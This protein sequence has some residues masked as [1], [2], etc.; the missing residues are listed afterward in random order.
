[1]GEVSDFAEPLNEI[2]VRLEAEQSE[3][4]RDDQEII[5]IR[6]ITTWAD[7][8]MPWTYFIGIPNSKSYVI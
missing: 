7:F 8:M 3:R 6:H 1:M 2:A 4:K 5:E